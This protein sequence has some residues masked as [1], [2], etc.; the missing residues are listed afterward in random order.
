MKVNGT[1]VDMAAELSKAEKDRVK[2]SPEDTVTIS[3]PM[4]LDGFHRLER[5]GERNPKMDARI[6]FF[7]EALIS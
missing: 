7:S 1:E 4:M 5:S 3:G 2:I 6:R